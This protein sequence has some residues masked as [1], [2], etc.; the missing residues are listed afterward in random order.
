MS[1]GPSQPP[2]LTPAERTELAAAITTRMLSAN[3]N[4]AYIA[5]GRKQTLRP[6]ESWRAFTPKA[7]LVEKVNKDRHLKKDYIKEYCEKALQLR[8]ERQGMPVVSSP[9]WAPKGAAKK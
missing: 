4:S 9:I 7:D 3:V 1:G 2:A 8:D 6:S 5:M